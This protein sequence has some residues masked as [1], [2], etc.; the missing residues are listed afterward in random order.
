MSY[1]YN[2]GF[3]S[4]QSGTSNGRSCYESLIKGRI[5]VSG[6]DASGKQITRVVEVDDG[7]VMSNRYRVGGKVVHNMVYGKFESTVTKRGR[8]VTRFNPKTGTGKHGKSLR[9]STLF[10]HDGCCHSWFKQGRLM[11]QK[12]IY[13]NRRIAYD[14]RFGSKQCEVRDYAG[15]L[16]YRVKGVIDGREQWQGRSVFEGPFNEWFLSSKPFSIERN[17]QIIYAGQ[18]RN[19]QKVGRWIQPDS[20][21]LAE[22]FGMKDEEYRPVEVFY[23][24]GVAI[25]KALYDLPPEKLEPRKLLGIS[26]AQLRMAMLSRANFKAERLAEIGTVIHRDGKMRLYD[27]PGLETRILKVVCPSTSSQYHIHVPKDSKKCEAAR[28]WTFHVGAGVRATREK[29]KF[30]VET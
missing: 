4:I 12:F 25:P 29:I 8:E 21:T 6:T 5:T 23:E 19:G 17:S 10:G 27:I 16:L 18:Y 1:G 24:H 13:D 22:S 26:N 9:F 20:K 30:E 3:V 28:Q 2:R 14:W 15:E 11:R 7:K